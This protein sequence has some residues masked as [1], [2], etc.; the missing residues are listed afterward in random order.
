MGWDKICRRQTLSE[1]FIEKHYKKMNW[2]NL[3]FH[4]HYSEKFIN[5][6]SDKFDLYI[7]TFSLAASRRILS[8]DFINKYRK[9]MSP[10]VRKKLRRYQKL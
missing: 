3:S 4:G 6:H 8:D 9:D 10:S 7:L 2:V 5:K 1:S